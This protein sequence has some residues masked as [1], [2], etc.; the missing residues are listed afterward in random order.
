MRIVVVSRY[1]DNSACRAEIMRSGG[2]AKTASNNNH[3]GHGNEIPSFP[4]RFQARNVLFF[5]WGLNPKRFYLKTF[6]C[7]SRMRVKT[8][9]LGFNRSVT[10]GVM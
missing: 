2:E 3:M 6:A 8:Y 4:I 1:L 9:I 7:E 5:D 10:L